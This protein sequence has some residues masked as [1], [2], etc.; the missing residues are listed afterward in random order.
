MVLEVALGLLSPLIHCTRRASL[1]N[2]TEE[3]A[4]E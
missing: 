3:Y 4:N 1:K 2:M